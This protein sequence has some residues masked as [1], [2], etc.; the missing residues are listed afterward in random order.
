MCVSIEA[1]GD[2]DELGNAELAWGLF[3]KDFNKTSSVGDKLG[4]FMKDKHFTIVRDDGFD[5]VELIKNDD[6]GE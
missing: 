6:K 3:L 4:F 2:N 5:D 1:C